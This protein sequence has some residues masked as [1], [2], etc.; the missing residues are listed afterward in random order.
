MSRK[1]IDLPKQYGCHRK[2]KQKKPYRKSY[3]KYRPYKQQYKNF[4]IQP[5]KTFRRRKYIPK[6]FR[7]RTNKPWIRKYKV[8]NKSTCKCYFCGEVG[9]IRPKCP[10]LGK[11]PREKIQLIE[12]FQ[13]EDN[14]D[15]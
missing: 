11:Q 5:S 7:K 10:K 1:N 9:H 14:E 15:L 3:R 2:F 6:Q 12:Q 4:R 13:L 8:P